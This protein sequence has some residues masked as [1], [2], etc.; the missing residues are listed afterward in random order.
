M[1]DEYAL[2]EAFSKIKQEMDDIRKEIRN[3]NEK[4]NSISKEDYTEELIESN[5]VIE[6]NKKFEEEINL[7]DSYY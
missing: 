2:R 1:I 5:P 4:L 7:T 3:V 6:N